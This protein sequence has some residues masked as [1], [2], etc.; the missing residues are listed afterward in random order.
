MNKENLVKISNKLR[1]D[2]IN[3]IYNAGSGHPGGQCRQ[4]SKLDWLK[5]I[6]T[7]IIFD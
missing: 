3:T 4:L 5:I 6:L 1:K 2:I 7:T